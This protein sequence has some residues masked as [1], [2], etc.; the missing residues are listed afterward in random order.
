MTR[1]RAEIVLSGIFAVAAAGT[2]VVPDWIEAVFGVDPDHGSGTLEWA[3]V[4]V[5]GLAAIG[6]ALLGRRDYLRGR[7]SPVSG[8]TGS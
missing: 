3:L 6:A 2:A 4:V 8:Q 7:Q 1:A 5:L